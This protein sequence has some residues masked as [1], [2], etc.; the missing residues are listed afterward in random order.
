MNEFC[1]LVRQAPVVHRKR[2]GHDLVE[3]WPIPVRRPDFVTVFIGLAKS[4]VVLDQVF[5]APGGGTG[6]DAMQLGV[7]RIEK[8][9]QRGQPLLSVNDHPL[10]EFPDGILNMLQDHSPKEMRLMLRVRVLKQPRRNPLQVLPKRIP[11]LFFVP[12]IGPLKQRNQEPLRLAEYSVGRSNL[13]F[14]PRCSYRCV[15]R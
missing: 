8:D 13:S 2:R 14:H 10:L 15:M 4:F 6:L 5:Q 12:D 3:C 9:L 1:R 11:L 7:K